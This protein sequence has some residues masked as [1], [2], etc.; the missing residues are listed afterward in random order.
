MK[1]LSIRWL[2][3]LVLYNPLCAIADSTEQAAVTIIIDD[4]GYNLHQGLRAVAL[5]GPVTFA[6]LP[7]SPHSKNLAQIA[8]ERGKEVMLHMPMDNDHGPSPGPGMLTAT[9]DHNLFQ[10]QLEQAIQAVPHL[11]GINNHM[12][13]S[14]TQNARRMR[15]VMESIKDHSLYFIDSRTSPLSVAGATARHQQI[16]S[17]DR[18]V[19]LDHDPAPAAIDK[20]FKRLISLA[21]KQGSAVA[22]GHPYPSTLGY[23]ENVIPKLDAM[24][25][26]LVSPSGLL[27]LNQAKTR[28]TEP[29][30]DKPFVTASLPANH[31]HCAITEQLAQRIVTC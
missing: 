26:R 20:Q 27:M 7:F 2:W 12:G 6:V 23:L 22:I 14:L 31:S 11:Q 1:G 28:R 9:Q 19:F 3:L 5:P 29:K 21:K 10:Q 18:D 30:F 4:L 17:L 8:H 25:I 24:G 16:P 13:S 15:W